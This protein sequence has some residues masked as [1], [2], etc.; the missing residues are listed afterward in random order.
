MDKLLEAAEARI[1]ETTGAPFRIA[2]QDRLGGGCI[3]DATRLRGED[4]RFFFLKQNRA[5]LA[6]SFRIEAEALGELHAAGGLRVP[7]PYG[8]VE[9]DGEAALLL[10]YLPMGGGTGKARYE[11]LGRGLARVHETRK[12]AF[13]WHRDNWIGSTPQYNGFEEDWV[14]FWREKRLRPQIEWARERGLR[15]RGADELL[16]VLPAFF[17]SY[18]PEPSLL[19]GDLWTGNVEFM[20]DGSPVIFDPATYYGDRETD[21]AMTEMFGGFPAAFWKAYEAEWPIDRGYRRRRDLYNLYHLLN[22]YN[23]FGGG[24]GASAERTVTSLLRA[25]GS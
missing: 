3:H 2:D 4:G 19:H 15:L 14:T 18:S 9:S 1:S 7:K 8:V 20:G 16:E 12:P 13:G 11:D 17:E 25:S 24:Y 23:L 10:E 6:E 22:H 21:L 5:D